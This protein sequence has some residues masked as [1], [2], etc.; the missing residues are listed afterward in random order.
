MK[1]NRFMKKTDCYPPVYQRKAF[2]FH[3]KPAAAANFLGFPLVFLSILLMLTG[4][5]TTL[6]KDVQRTP[7]TAFANYDTRPQQGN[8][9]RKQR[10]GTPGN[11]VLRSSAKDGGP[12]RAE[13][14]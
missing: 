9:L 1:Y 14:P 6:P 2:C 5:A 4:C 13:L 11:R 12:S 3:G 8:F 7:S 10:F